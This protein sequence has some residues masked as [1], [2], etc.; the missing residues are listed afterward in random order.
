MKRSTIGWLAVIILAGVPVTVLVGLQ[1]AANLAH[2][3]R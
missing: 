2:L 3:F 1:N